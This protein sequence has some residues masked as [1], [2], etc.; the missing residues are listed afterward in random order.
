MSE[1][2]KP[3]V[4][5]AFLNFSNY[6]HSLTKSI[7][8]VYKWRIKVNLRQFR[9]K[10]VPISLLSHW[11]QSACPH[12]DLT[13]C[14]HTMVKTERLEPYYYFGVMRT[15]SDVSQMAFEWDFF[16]LAKVNYCG[17]KFRLA[18]R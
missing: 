10:F 7:S 17:Q 18:C 9:P 6:S 8:G 11:S 16:S 5:L 12:F 3:L 13:I 1:F 15:V 4:L 2:E 14:P